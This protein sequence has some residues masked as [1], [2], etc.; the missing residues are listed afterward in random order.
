M[1]ADG[2][3]QTALTSNTESAGAPAWSLDGTKIA[4]QSFASGNVDIYVI[5]ADG[6]GRSQLTTD[7]AE[8][9]APAWAR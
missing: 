2:S 5:N 9:S 4:F 1:N 3:G 6:S 8:D 7:P